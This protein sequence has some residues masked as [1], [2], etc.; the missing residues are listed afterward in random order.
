R[1]NPLRNSPRALPIGQKH[2][3]SRATLDLIACRRLDMDI[4]ARRF[5]AR[6]ER[7]VLRHPVIL[8]NAYT[9]WFRDGEFDE[10]HARAF[11]TQFSV[12]SNQFLVAQLHKMLNA[13]TLEEMRESKEIL[14]NEIGVGFRVERQRQAARIAERNA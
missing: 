4:R 7:D 3:A 2:Y 6:L 13:E 9:K 5:K 14:A 1:S 10:T 8:A 12:F 11:L